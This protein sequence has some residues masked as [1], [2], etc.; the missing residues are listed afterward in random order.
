MNPRALWRRVYDAPYGTEASAL[1]ALAVAI[2]ALPLLGGHS[3]V[4]APGVVSGCGLALE[5]VGIM[6]VYRSNRFINFAQVAIGS[7][8]AALFLA[9]VQFQAMPR[10]VTSVCPT[11]LNWS[12]QQGFAPGS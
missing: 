4:H 1:A 2:V 6:L 8:A 10:L 7:L 9:S 12:Q 11:C 5:A 3:V